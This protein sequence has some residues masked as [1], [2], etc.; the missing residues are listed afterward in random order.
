MGAR[1][2]R[3][4]RRLLG[5]ILA[6]VGLYLSAG[7][8]HVLDPSNAS[9]LP[10]EAGEEVLFSGRAI[11]LENGYS[12]PQIRPVGSDGFHHFE[13]DLRDW[14][15]RLVLELAEELVAR[16]ARVHVDP[17]ALK[18]TAVASLPFAP[19]ERF[20]TG[21]SGRTLRVTVN[22]IKTPRFGAGKGLELSA[23]IE[24]R[25]GE[26]SAFYHAET[27]Q[28]FSDIFFVMKRKILDDPPFQGWLR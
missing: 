15:A 14:S 16:G 3:E 17:A 21:S 12:E 27:K 19:P 18:D 2:S 10:L 28:S 13:I 5:I 22:E 24:D 23:T 7:C 20:V 6:G 9:R 4:P 1:A 25:A 26:L 11:R 8:Y